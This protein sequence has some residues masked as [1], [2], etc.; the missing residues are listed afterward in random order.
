MSY[1]VHIKNGMVC[2]RLR[3]S[4]VHL[5]PYSRTRHAFEGVKI[6]AD[7]TEIETSYHTPSKN[8]IPAYLPVGHPARLAAERRA[9]KFSQR[10]DD[11][12]REKCSEDPIDDPS[13]PFKRLRDK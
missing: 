1:C 13:M 9:L 4:Y 8:M 5:E 12:Q 2:R 10:F 6:D 7:D 3:A 11:L